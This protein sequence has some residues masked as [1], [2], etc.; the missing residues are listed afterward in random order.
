LAPQARIASDA[1]ARKTVS[2]ID[3]GSTVA[4]RVGSTFVDVGLAERTRIANSAGTSKSTSNVARASSCSRDER[5][6]TTPGVLKKSEQTSI[7][8]RTGDA[9]VDRQRAGVVPA[10]LVIAGCK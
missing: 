1:S 2:S 7:L 9:G 8:A 3:T 4:A 10:D 5:L 6:K